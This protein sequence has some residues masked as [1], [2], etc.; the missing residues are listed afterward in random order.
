M[1]KLVIFAGPRGV[2]MERFNRM[3]DDRVQ[4]NEQNELG[5]QAKKP[6]RLRPFTDVPPS[7]AY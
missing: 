1:S 5:R 6:S 3:Y 2:S 4:S 7:K